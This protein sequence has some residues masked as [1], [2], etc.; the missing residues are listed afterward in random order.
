MVVVHIEKLIHEIYEEVLLMIFWI[1][2]LSSR[3]LGYLSQINTPSQY[4]IS[5]YNLGTYSET[6]KIFL[7]Y[8]IRVKQQ[9][10]M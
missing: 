9:K 4:I 1:L 7:V 6:L 8:R 10:I 5:E 2:N 3:L